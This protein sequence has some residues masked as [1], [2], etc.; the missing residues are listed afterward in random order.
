MKKIIIWLIIIA[1]LNSCWNSSK[2]QEEWSCI[3]DW[4]V[5]YSK[6]K[7]WTLGWAQKWCSCEEIRNF[8]IKTFWEVDEDALKNDFWC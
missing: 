6:N 5:M 3:E 1:L 4:T 8:E 2:N 7:S